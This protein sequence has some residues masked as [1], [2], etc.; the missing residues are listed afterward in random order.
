VA[1]GTFDSIIDQVRLLFDREYNRG[2]EDVT[3]R[4]IDAAQAGSSRRPAKRVLASQK[5][6]ISVPNLMAAATGPTESRVSTA[7]I[8]FE[9]FKGKKEKMYRSVKGKWSLSKRPAKK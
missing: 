3:K 7:A 4:L 9:L 6:G 2:A 1:T 5:A 8:R